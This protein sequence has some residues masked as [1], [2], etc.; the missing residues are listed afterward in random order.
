MVCQDLV[1][2]EY[3]YCDLRLQFKSSRSKAE[4]APHIVLTFQEWE[5]ALQE[6]SSLLEG[7]NG[8]YDG[9]EL[10]SEHP[11]FAEP[12]PSEEEPPH[13]RPHEGAYPSLECDQ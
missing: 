8:V 12:F 2:Q 11:P 13:K 4:K 7:K 6:L 10:S 3:L 9:Q 5:D 1:T